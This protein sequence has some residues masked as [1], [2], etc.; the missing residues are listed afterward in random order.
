[1]NKFNRLLCYITEYSEGIPKDIRIS[2]A[3]NSGMIISL[4]TV[5]TPLWEDIKSGRVIL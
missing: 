3:A 1:M 2:F 5:N 4:D